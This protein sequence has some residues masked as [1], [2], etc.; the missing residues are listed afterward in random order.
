MKYKW[1]VLIKNPAEY[2]PPSNAEV[3]NAW[4][5]TPTSQY[6]YMGWC[7][8]KDR[9]DFTSYLSAPRPQTHFLRQVLP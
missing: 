7:L 9:E 2:S 1:E 3:K 6:T 4:S 5:S 8:V